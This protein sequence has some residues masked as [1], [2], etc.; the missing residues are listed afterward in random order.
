MK[1]RLKGG[2]ILIFLLFLI[3]PLFSGCEDDRGSSITGPQSTVTKDG[4]TLS[5]QLD[6]TKIGLN[7]GET[8]TITIIAKGAFSGE[9][10]FILSYTSNNKLEPAYDSEKFSL[11]AGKSAASF[12]KVINGVTPTSTGTGVITA[13]FTGLGSQIT[14]ITTSTEVAIE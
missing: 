1:Y 9:N 5:I 10:D 11:A 8:L 2:M 7:S 3:L 12:F 6:K 4:V 13:T 14:T